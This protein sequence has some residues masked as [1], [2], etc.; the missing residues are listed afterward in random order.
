MGVRGL[1]SAS[2]E[3]SRLSNY[4][5]GGDTGGG[6]RYRGGYGGE[7]RAGVRGGV[8]GGYGGEVRGGYGGG[9]WGGEVR[10]GGT[11]GGTGG[12]LRGGG[13]TGGGTGGRLL[14]DYRAQVQVVQLKPK[15]KQVHRP[16]RRQSPVE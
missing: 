9:V 13:G 8:R 16:Q 5:Y 7:V 11:G 4:G 15:H 14:A 10:G 2:S 6:G 12:G 1:A 3:A